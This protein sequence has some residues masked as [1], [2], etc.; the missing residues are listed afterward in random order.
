M[1]SEHTVQEAHEN[2]ENFPEDLPQENESLVA[3]GRSLLVS[4]VQENITG[5]SL[6]LNRVDC[7]ELGLEGEEPISYL[8][9]SNYL[10]KATEVFYSVPSGPNSTF[11]LWRG[12][13]AYIHQQTLTHAV[14]ALMNT[15][16][17]SYELALEHLEGNDKALACVEYSNLLLYYNKYEEAEQALMKAQETTKLSYSLTGKMGV[18]TKFQKEKKPQLVLDV[19]SQNLT[20]QET[21]QPESVPL[22]EEDI[23]L[24]TP[25]IDEHTVES[26][27]LVDQVILLGWVNYLLKAKPKDEIN[28]EVI[29]A[30][31]DVM[32]SKSLNWLVYSQALFFRSKNQFTS[33]RFKERSALQIQTLL[34][35]YNDPD[36]P[37]H[38]RLKYVFALNY[39]L[40]HWM[41]VELGEMFMKLGAVMSAY[42]E[43]E[44]VGMWEEAIECLIMGNKPNQAIKLAKE[45]LEVLESPR[46]LCALADVTREIVYYERA[47]EVS[48]H[49]YARA[50]RS[51]G[52]HYFGQGNL[53]ECIQHFK[54]ALEVNGLYPGIWFTYSC[55]LMKLERWEEATYALQRMVRVDSSV[56]EGWNNLAAVYMRRNML[57]EAF[58]AMSYGVK[59]D[60]QNWK[61]WENLLMLSVQIEEFPQALEAIRHLLRLDQ[62][63]LFDS[64]LFKIINTYARESLRVQEVFRLYTEVLRKLSSNYQIWEVYADFLA[65]NRDH[66]E[67]FS[68]EKV[69]DAKI[70]A[71]RNLMKPGW[72]RDPGLCE[73]ALKLLKQL[74]NTYNLT[75]SQKKKTEGRMFIS[76]A[77]AKIQSTLGREVEI[78]F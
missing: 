67:E 36:P 43:F 21:K 6:S 53:E 51:L 15:S 48:N 52:K 55:A 76:N 7:D 2:L 65:E 5:P 29:G 24:E 58:S 31:L 78:K 26:I 22:D 56:S 12:R 30:Y 59:N 4:F 9:G 68:I 32:L 35:Q 23:M 34:D 49:R 66:S 50:Q 1:I 72:D 20:E 25:K 14:E 42:Q 70:K 17:E 39:P 62:T 33:Y 46:I 71:C 64:Q 27:P 63:R 8:I 3:L 75:G 44:Q 74:A 54:Q 57:K 18:R 47:W 40:R 61:M 60:R 28:S 77:V 11:Y 38:E 10:L 19:D 41:I 69:L 16:I 45:R 73:E 37:A 13:C